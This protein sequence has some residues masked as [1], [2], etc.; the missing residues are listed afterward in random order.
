MPSPDRRA[1]LD[2]MPGTDIPVLRQPFEAGD[3]MPIWAFGEHAIG[4][5]Y[6]YDL[7]VDPDEGENRIGEKVEKEMTE[8]LRVALKSVESPSEQLTRTGIN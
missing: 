1:W 2:T 5:H 4:K 7:M 8:L 6:L 3:Q